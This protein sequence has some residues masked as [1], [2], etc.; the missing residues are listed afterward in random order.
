MKKGII[1]ILLCLISLSAAAQDLTSVFL[2]IPE[3]VLF[4]L[5]AENKDKLINTATDSVTATATSILGGDIIRKTVTDDYLLFETSSAGTLQIKLLPL[6]NNSRIICVVKTVCG[7]ACDSNVRFYS[8]DWTLLPGAALLP[9]TDINWFIKEDADK[10][11]ED[12]VNAFAA[13]DMMPVK[14]TLDASQPIANIT[15]DIENY[16]SEDDYKKIKP[17]LNDTPKTLT[18]D[19]TSFK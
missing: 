6:V 7:K 17:Y 13:V 19:R 14:I 1:Y 15:L 5:D 12:F 10:K 4:G 18:W 3:D 2:K 11:N 9:E 8:T 16:L